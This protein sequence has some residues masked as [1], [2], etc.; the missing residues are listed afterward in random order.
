[1]SEHKD[2]N[3]FI[4]IITSGWIWCFVDAQHWA[5]IAEEQTRVLVYY[6]TQ[7][8]E[9][10]GEVFVRYVVVPVILAIVFV[11]GMTGNG[12]LLSIFVRHKETRTLANSMLINLNKFKYM[13][14]AFWL[15]SFT[16]KF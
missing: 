14:L 11:V 2:E 12:L 7:L 8:R 6:Q 15:R 4:N 13:A 9:V 10:Q 3:P 16:F 1:M 5:K